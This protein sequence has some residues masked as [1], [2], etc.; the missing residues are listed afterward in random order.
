MAGKSPHLNFLGGGAAT[1]PC[2]RTP[3]RQR[4]EKRQKNDSNM[5]S[6]SSCRL[7]GTI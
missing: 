4:L 6:V 5:A 1:G 3:P 7:E 2:R